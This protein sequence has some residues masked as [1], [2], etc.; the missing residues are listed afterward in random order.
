VK[1]G[2][3]FGDA[4]VQIKLV[5]GRVRRAESFVAAKG[6]TDNGYIRETAAVLQRVLAN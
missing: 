4:S 2:R 3:I 1:S 6:N 5:L